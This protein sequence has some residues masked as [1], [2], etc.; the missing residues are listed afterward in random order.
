M[1][2]TRN[3]MGMQDSFDQRRASQG[4]NNDSKMY[5][6]VQMAQAYASTDLG[7]PRLKSSGG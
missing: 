4:A 1:A 3:K 5:K 2:L 6:Q 7:A